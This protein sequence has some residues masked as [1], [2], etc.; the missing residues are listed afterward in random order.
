[1]PGDQDCDRKKADTMLPLQITY[2]NV[3]ASTQAENWVRDQVAKLDRCYNRITICRVLIEIPH[4]H[5]EWGR[6]YH[7][8]VEVGVPGTELVVKNE[9]TLRASTG[10]A[11]DKRPV[12]A[13]RREERTKDL[14]LAIRNA[15]SAA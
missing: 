9:A 2:R 8:R 1:M 14:H 10:R 4:A 6:T 13:L 11:T 15:F 12:K 7:V 5:R 3:E